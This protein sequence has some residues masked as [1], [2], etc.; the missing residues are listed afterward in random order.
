MRL[1]TS[2][3]TCLLHVLNLDP[4]DINSAKR[5][6]KFTRKCLCKLYL[7]TNITKT[8]ITSSRLILSTSDI[9]YI[10]QILQ[11]ISHN[12]KWLSCS[13]SHP[14]QLN[15]FSILLSNT[16][17]DIKHAM[18]T[19][20]TKSIMNVTYHHIMLPTDLPTISP[21][22]IDRKIDEKHLVPRIPTNLFKSSSSIKSCFMLYLPQCTLY[23]MLLQMLC[24]CKKSSQPNVFMPI[25]PY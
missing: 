18:L 19:S 23:Q 9:N 13:I 24:S 22:H 10:Y 7:R 14:Y 11:T 4:Q 25:S 17:E 5:Y 2:Y 21:F 8:Y 3:S 12:L 16:V 6:N 20:M 15:H 1:A